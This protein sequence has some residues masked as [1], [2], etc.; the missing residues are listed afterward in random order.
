MPRNKWDMVNYTR[1]NL[2]VVESE[3]RVMQNW[4]QSYLL[5]IGDQ[6]P[7]YNNACML[8]ER[9]DRWGRYL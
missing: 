7:C 4:N 3:V 1:I 5:E 2:Q 6:K 8:F 9:I